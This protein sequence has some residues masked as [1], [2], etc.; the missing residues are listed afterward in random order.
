MT[1]TAITF[2]VTLDSPHAESCC[3]HH[4]FTSGG[5]GWEVNF[6]FSN[7]WDE[8]P[9]RNAVFWAGDLRVSVPIVDNVAVI[10]E[11][12]QKRPFVNLYVGVCGK[13]REPEESARL[14]A[15]EINV[16]LDEIVDAIHSGASGDVLVARENLTLREEYDTLGM[17]TKIVPSTWCKLGYIL[18]GACPSEETTVSEEEG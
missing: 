7:Y 10:P 15:A 13:D 16:R 4:L 8:L 9:F 6:S 11:N 5:K 18:P 12:I 14:R 17:P 3:R 2:P 1:H